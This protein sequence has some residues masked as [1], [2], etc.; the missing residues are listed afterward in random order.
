[1]TLSNS[2]RLKRLA[3]AGQGGQAQGGAGE[4]PSGGRGY[5]HGARHSLPDPDVARRQ[6]RSGYP[7][8]K[9]LQQAPR[10]TAARRGEQVRIHRRRLLSAS[11]AC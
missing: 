6:A 4:V 11:N 8:R 1:M 10:R 5:D 3:Q 7:H 9:L 2:D